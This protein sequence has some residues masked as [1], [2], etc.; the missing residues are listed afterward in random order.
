LSLDDI[1]EAHM[2]ILIFVVGALLGVL[3]GGAICVRYL[4]HE[5]A[6]DM[7]P[8]LR[9]MQL[10]LDNLEAEIN[11]ALMMRHAELTGRLPHH[12]TS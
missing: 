11:L 2:V 12:P 5:V 9:R 7:V 10:Q 6:A 3:V 8:R 1:K 4:R